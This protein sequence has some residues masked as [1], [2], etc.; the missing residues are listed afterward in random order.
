MPRFLL[1]AA[2]ACILAATLTPAGT[3]VE[4]EFLRCLLCGARGLS[5]SLV[6][7]ILFAPLGITLALNGRHGMRAVLLGGMLSCGVELAQIFI[8][9]RDP[10]L[11]DV[12]ANTL[13]TAAGQ[14]IFGLAGRWLLPN[15]RA[16]ARLSLLAA[17]LLL[18][19]FNATARLLEPSLPT[20]TVRTWYTPDRPDLEWYH[21]RVLRAKLG[22]IAL[23]PGRPF[24]SAA[25]RGLLLDEAPLRIDATAGQ[26]VRGLAPLLVIEDEDGREVI[27]AG[28]DREDLVFRYVP[29]ASRWRLDQPD[30]RLR[31]AFAAVRPGDTVQIAIRRQGRGVC[32]A[33]NRSARC[34]I[35]NSIGSGW[36]LLYYPRHFPVWAYTLL[37]AGW[38]AGLAFPI[39]LWARR[40]PETALAVALLCV[41]LFVPFTGLIRTPPHQLVGAAAGLLLGRL[42]QAWRRAVSAGT[43]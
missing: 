21:G 10:S 25:V 30:L 36:A 6:N 27:L 22:P 40:R 41:A 13:G 18:A 28:I 20:G 4:S 23:R 26:A 11:G 7:I 42:L 38:V 16:A 1:T 29:R 17:G 3:V 35:G 2:V 15:A 14:A 43:G 24:E 33:L 5:D 9:G 12:V 8:P 32:L 37:E 19:V 39:G 34:D 31:H